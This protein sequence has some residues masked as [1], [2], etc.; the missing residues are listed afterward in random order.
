MTEIK[1]IDGIK[2]IATIK[3]GWR[4]KPLDKDRLL[5]TH[6]DHFPRVVELSTIVEGD[7]LPRDTDMM[8]GSPP[9]IGGS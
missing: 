9:G 7:K 3:K 1:N 2:I 8:V 5:L 6:P 4:S